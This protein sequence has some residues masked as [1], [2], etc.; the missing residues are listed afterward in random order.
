MKCWGPQALCDSLRC[1]SNPV[2]LTGRRFI[3]KTVLSTGAS[4]LNPHTQTKHQSLGLKLEANKE[5]VK[6]YLLEWPLEGDSKSES[7][8]IES[9]VKIL[10]SS[11]REKK[12]VCS[13]VQKWFWFLAIMPHQNNSMRG[14]SFLK[15]TYLNLTWGLK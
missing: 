10:S 9:N 8:L 13:F 1:Y 15:L 14:D 6:L 12:H 5:V 11:S 3:L 4:A 2:C 7:V